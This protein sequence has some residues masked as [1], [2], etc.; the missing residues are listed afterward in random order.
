MSTSGVPPLVY[1]KAANAVYI[2]FVFL[3]HLIES[4]MQLYLSFDGDE[5]VLKDVE[6]YLLGPQCKKVKELYYSI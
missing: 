2:G 6:G 1:E 5:A 3:K 4:G